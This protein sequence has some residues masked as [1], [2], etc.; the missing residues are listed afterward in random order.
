MS[1]I[2]YIKILKEAWHIAWT[3]KYLWLL[4]F[5]VA[6]WEAL[7]NIFSYSN[8]DQNGNLSQFLTQNQNKAIFLTVLGIFLVVCLVFLIL[9][10]IGRGGLIKSIEREIK[11]KPSDF[12]SGLRV[13]RKYFWPMFTLGLFLLVLLFL[14]TLVLAVPVVF[15]FYRGAY[16]FGVMMAVM[17]L[18]IFI[19]LIIIL[20]FAKTYGYIYIVLG[21]LSPLASL[22]AAYNLFLSHLVSSLI[23]GL[24]LIAVSIVFGIGIILGLLPL[25]LFFFVL[26]LFAKLIL[27]TI[28]VTI[29]IAIGVILFLVIIL[30]LRSAYETF[31]QS[32]WILFFFEIASPKEPE[33]VEEAEKVEK[34]ETL[35]TASPVNPIK[36]IESEKQ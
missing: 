19:P 11:K 3:N 22:E 21:K 26:G 4:G 17:A 2:N 1:D 30:S 32:A 24:L 12:K 15:L 36:T 27:G 6:L 33:K 34:V 14:F 28:G 20:A 31:T 25:A 29:V 10:M 16:I 23:M 35:P 9:G 5:F 8:P 18:V 13:G 7:G